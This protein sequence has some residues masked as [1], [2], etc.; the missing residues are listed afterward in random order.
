VCV[1]GERRILP[2]IARR[3]AL[4]GDSQAY[5]DFFVPLRRAAGL[6]GVDHLT[7][8]RRLLQGLTGGLGP[9]AQAIT[10]WRIRD[11]LRPKTLSWWSQPRSRWPPDYGHWYGYAVLDERRGP[12]PPRVAMETTQTSLGQPT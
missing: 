2:N 7:A 10:S 1:A 12:H 3:G 6:G 11:P 5:V 8:E 4:V 9:P